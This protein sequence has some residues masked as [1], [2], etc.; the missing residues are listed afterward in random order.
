MFKGEISLITIVLL[1]QVYHLRDDFKI[2]L[3][4]ALKMLLAIVCR[5]V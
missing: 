5:I 3:I 1:D 2:A 4:T